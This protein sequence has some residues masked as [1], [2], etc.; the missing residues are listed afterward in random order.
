M[1]EQALIDSF[2]TGL[3]TGSII[4]LLVG[5]GLILTIFLMRNK[6][7]TTKEKY[8]SIFIIYSLLMCMLYIFL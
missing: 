5:L 3:L 2:K 7:D 6:P 1:D 8:K 4:L